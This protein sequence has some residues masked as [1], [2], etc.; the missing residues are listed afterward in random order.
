MMKSGD[1]VRLTWS[2]GDKE[3]GIFQ[4]EER[5]FAVLNCEGKRVVGCLSSLDKIEV[6]KQNENLETKEYNK[7]MGIESKNYFSWR[8]LFL[9][10]LIS[11]MLLFM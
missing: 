11:C 8:S 2:D 4:R 3:V 5:G 7:Y 10:F 6:L 9:F 1:L